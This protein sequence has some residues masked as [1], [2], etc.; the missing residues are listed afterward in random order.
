MILLQEHRERKVGELAA[1]FVGKV[2][3][4]WV[5]MREYNFD[6]E[7]GDKGIPGKRIA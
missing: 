7:I 6:M 3:L 1:S 2:A 5:L 4:R